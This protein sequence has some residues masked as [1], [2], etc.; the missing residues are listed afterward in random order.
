MTW[1][2][3]YLGHREG[4]SLS[5]FTGARVTLVAGEEFP[6]PA[7][8][9]VLGRGTDTDLRVASSHVARRHVRLVPHEGGVEVVDLGSTNGTQWQ[10]REPGA[11]LRPGDRLTLAEAF[12]FELIE[13]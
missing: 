8:G 6:I 10:P 4:A 12:D 11:L 1:A 5:Y 3:R 9:L 13:I 2:L 7:Q